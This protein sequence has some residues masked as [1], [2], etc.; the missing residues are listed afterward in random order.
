MKKQLSIT[1]MQAVAPQPNP[2]FSNIWFNC[3]RAKTTKARSAAEQ[4]TMRGMNQKTPGEPMT[5][6]STIADLGLP[7]FVRQLREVDDMENLVACFDLWAPTV[8]GY[9]PLDH[10][11]GRQH[12]RA[13]LA[14][15][16]SIGSANFMLYVVMAFSGRPL[17]NLEHGFIAE[18]VESAKI[19][20]LP[21]LVSDG[22]MAEVAVLGADI[23]T[24][25]EH[26]EFMFRALSV[27]RLHPELFYNYVVEL[28]SGGQGES[29]GAAVYLLVGAAFSGV[30]H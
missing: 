8:T 17:G 24:M 7:S 23:E 14:Y 1:P 16:H 2:Q 18:L 6:N 20:R 26:E 21:P 13:A 22:L 12:C 19:G 28:I 27:G 29:I 4:M 9:A 3:Q 30:L 11:L 25:R 15:S 10:D 5:D